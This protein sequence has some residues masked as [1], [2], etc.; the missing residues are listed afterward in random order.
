M[1]G[2]LAQMTSLWCSIYADDVQLIMI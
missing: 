2:V 1:H